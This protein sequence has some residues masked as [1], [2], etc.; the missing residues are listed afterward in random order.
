MR[1]K[2]SRYR[3]ITGLSWPVVIAYTANG[4]LGTSFS[5]GIMPSCVQRDQ[6]RTQSPVLHAK[7]NVFGSTP[8]CFHAAEILARN[9]TSATLRPCCSH[10]NPSS[11]S[12][13]AVVLAVHLPSSYAAAAISQALRN[14]SVLQAQSTTRARA[15]SDSNLE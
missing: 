2:T 13:A 3:H 4:T 7:S 8:R 11:F 12:L 10:L 9:Y 15:R 14:P 1:T 6:G 5:A